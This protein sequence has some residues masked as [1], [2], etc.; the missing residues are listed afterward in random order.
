MLLSCHVRR[1]CSENMNY[2]RAEKTYRRYFDKRA[3]SSSPRAMMGQNRLLRSSW[4]FKTKLNVP[5]LWIAGN[6]NSQSYDYTNHASNTLVTSHSLLTVLLFGE[7]FFCD[8]LLGF[9]GDVRKRPYCESVATLNACFVVDR[10]S[11]RYHVVA[12]ECCLMFLYIRRQIKTTF[13]YCA[14]FIQTFKYA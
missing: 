12:Y 2:T 1:H 7:A 10:V 8:L 3:G 5:Y 13:F 9:V 4:R 11:F 14:H 6:I